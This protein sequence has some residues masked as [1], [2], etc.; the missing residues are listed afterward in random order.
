L[1]T[2]TTKLPK[3]TKRSLYVSILTSTLK[4]NQTPRQKETPARAYKALK[5]QLP[6]SWQE[7]DLVLSNFP[8]GNLAMSKVILTTKP[9]T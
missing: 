6:K 1:R 4:R 7:S 8:N 3:R 9:A 2:R 5:I